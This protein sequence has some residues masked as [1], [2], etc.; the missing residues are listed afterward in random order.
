MVEIDDR[1]CTRIKKDGEQ[2]GNFP[3]HGLSVCK[4][5]G[6]GTI[7]ARR[8]SYE[9]KL[10]LSMRKMV[11]PIGVDDWESNPLNGFDMEY[12]RTIARI[13]YFDDVLSTMSEKSLTWG[14]TKREDKEATE[15][16]G[17]D[18]T[19]EAKVNVVYAM[20]FAERQH[21]VK[22][23]KIWIAAGLDNRRLQIEEQKVLAFDNAI[24]TILTSLGH[25]SRDPDVRAVVRTSML[26]LSSGDDVHRATKKSRDHVQRTE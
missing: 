21:L 25:D 8:K 16:G 15:F 4:F 14:K 2:C 3:L 12:R 13:R 7:G 20:Q 10:T 9:A 17:T 22:L 23:S 24:T 5:H 6:G 26:Q 19:Y 18:T 11:T 1:F